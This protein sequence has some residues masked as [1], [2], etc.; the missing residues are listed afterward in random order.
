MSVTTLELT[1]TSTNELLTNKNPP[2]STPDDSEDETVGNNVIRR[3]NRLSKLKKVIQCYI[4]QLKFVFQSVIP[5]LKSFQ[6]WKIIILILYAT[7]SVIFTIVDVNSFTKKDRSLLKWIN[8]RTDRVALWRRCLLCLSGVSAFTNV[9]NVVLVIHGKM[10]AY[11]WGILGAILYGPFAFAYGYAGDA[12]LFVLFFLPM[13]FVGIYTWSQELDTQATTRVKSLKL[14]GWLFV[15]LS[16][17]LV[18]LLFYYEIPWFAKLLTGK[19]FFEKIPIL[20][21]LDAATNGLSVIAQILMIAC[22]WEQYIIWTVVNLMLIVMYSGLYEKNLDINLLL[23]WIM[24]TIN[25]SCGLYTW[26]NRWKNSRH[27]SSTINIKA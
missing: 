26:F 7:F 18:I 9:L 17:S 24:L 20:H 22:Y 6:K 10:S 4:K 14:T 3:R 2:I 21:K 13:Q 27:S 23:V 25:S 19:Y 16:S 8:D 5:D 15:L 12:Q 1:D 11:F